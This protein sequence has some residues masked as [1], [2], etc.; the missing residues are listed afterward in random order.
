MKPP[1]QQGA[2]AEQEG[3]ELEPGA[4]WVAHWGGCGKLAKAPCSFQS[5]AST[6][7]ALQEQGLSFL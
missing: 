4:D 6:L 1:P 3:L 2:I 5:A 7:V